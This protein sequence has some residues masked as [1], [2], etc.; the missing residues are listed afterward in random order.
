MCKLVQV[1]TLL[2]QYRL[3]IDLSP[4]TSRVLW[5]C[6]GSVDNLNAMMLRWP[7]GM[8]AGHLG[9]VSGHA[10]GV[11]EVWRKAPGAMVKRRARGGAPVPVAEGGGAP[12]GK[13]G[14]GAGLR[15]ELTGVP[16]AAP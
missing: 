12:V 1:D 5:A 9:A 8:C 2:K 4:A 13:G 6:A 14:T 16:A 7:Q 15:W 3:Q 11:A 10:R